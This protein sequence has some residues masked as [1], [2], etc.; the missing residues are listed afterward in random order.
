MESLDLKHQTGDDQAALEQSVEYR[1]T[2]ARVLLQ[3]LHRRDPAWPALA[4]TGFFAVCA[5]AFAITAIMTPAQDYAP[6]PAH[7]A[8]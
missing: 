8:G 4:A 2:L 1:L 5:M 7:R 6:V 3:P